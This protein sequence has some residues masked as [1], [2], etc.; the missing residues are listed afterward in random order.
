MNVYMYHF[1]EIKKHYQ[2][3][4]KLT[5]TIESVMRAFLSAMLLV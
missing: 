2:I 1:Y 5:L 3:K 4:V